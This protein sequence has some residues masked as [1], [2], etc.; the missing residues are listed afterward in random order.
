MCRV[1]DGVVFICSDGIYKY[2]I[3]DG[4]VRRVCRPLK[5]YSAKA[6][7]LRYD[8]NTLIYYS[9]GWGAVLVDCRTWKTRRASFGGGDYVECMFV[10]SKKRIWL[11]F[12]SLGKGLFCYDIKGRLLQRYG[13]DESPF[14][15]IVLCMNEHHG[16]ILV[17]TD[18]N[19]VFSID[20]STHQAQAYGHI[21]GDNFYALPSNSICAIHVD[22]FDNMWAG[23]VRSGLLCVRPV[24]IRTFY[25]VPF[26]NPHGLSNSS[27]LCFHEEAPDRIW[28]GTDGGGLDLYSP[29]TDEFRHFESTAG[30]KILSICGLRP[31]Q[32]L[33]RVFARGIFVFNTLTGKQT[34][35][36][37]GRAATDAL[38]ARIGLSSELSQLDADNVLLCA[39]DCYLLNIRT[40]AVRKIKW[41]GGTKLGRNLHYLPSLCGGVFLHDATSIYQFNA[42][43]DTLSLVCRLKGDNVRINAVVRSNYGNFCIATNRG[44]YVYRYYTREFCPKPAYLFQN[45]NA[46]VTD[47]HRRLWLAT[48]NKVFVWINGQR[49]YM[50]Y[51]EMDGVL[52][53]EYVPRASFMSSTGDIYFGGTSGMVHIDK[54]YK[55]SK[56]TDPRILLTD[57]SINGASVPGIIARNHPELSVGW[58]DNISLRVMSVEH[59]L[60]R[61]KVYRFLIKGYSDNYTE[62]FNPQLDLRSLPSGHYQILASVMQIDGSWTGWQQVLDLTMMPPWYLNG[63]FVTACI[64]ILLLAL[65]FAS[66]SVLRRREERMRWQINSHERQ[67][68][69]DKMRF[70]IDITHELR[71]PLT[72]IH[73]PLDR[74]TKTLPAS[75]PYYERLKGL[76]RQTVRMKHLINMVLDVHKMETTE[77]KLH[78]QPHP[79]H[80][81]LRQVADDFASEGQAQNITTAYDFDPRIDMLSFDKDKCDM[82]LN[83]LLG[84]ALKHSSPGGHITVR[85][86]LSDDGRFVRISVSDDGPGMQGVDPGKLFSRFYQG[87][88]ETVGSGIGLSYSKILVEQHGGNIGA[89]NNEVAGATF[90]FELPMTAQPGDLV[91]QPHPCL[92]ELVETEPRGGGRITLAKD[93]DM[94]GYVLLVVDD[95]KALTDFLKESLRSYFKEVRTASDGVEALESINADAPDVVVSDVMMPRKDGFA[96]CKDIKEN[97]TI[98]HIVVILL[99]A[100]DDNSSQ[101]AG[102]KNGADGYVT[103]PFEIDTLLE[104]LG[105]RL[106]SR[107]QARNRYMSAGLL[108][109]VKDTTF[110]SADEA[111]MEQLDKVISDNISNPDIDIPMLC[112]E[113]AMSRSALY[114]KLKAITNMGSNDYVTKFRMETAVRLMKDTDLSFTDIS[115]KVGISSSRYFSTLFK[116]FIGETPTSY[117]KKLEEDKERK[118]PE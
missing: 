105:N 85:T 47:K 83:N 41:S 51:D 46:L 78:L 67:V 56:I 15:N 86:R 36:V 18:G 108:P 73:A 107:Q 27:A 3:S 22:R 76:Q 50:M 52:R 25:E 103:K 89:Y 102:Y 81:W 112:R 66:R 12:L 11:S 62:T 2:T 61:Q 29:S 115:E 65:F 40:S 58:D 24:T 55:V 26:G 17:G 99:T 91:N 75:N 79:L 72:L 68:N 101:I 34:P 1:K 98:S 60:L 100:R 45:V 39:D 90:Y 6:K 10:D 8:D 88:N 42:K 33:I 118:T 21:S 116:Q 9:S 13:G 117:R 20:P 113:M 23:T 54:D 95:N 87:G 19:G 104:L 28:V 70:L 38:L 44:W 77:T 32:L 63:W 80:E 94:S 31:H 69:V 106:R 82:V 109:V 35:F 53:N 30:E 71:T 59:N 43:L 93:F 7:I 74:M 92:A 57:L 5:P 14:G 16:H 64:L 84:N 111:F 48:D 37:T 4:I 96:L 114:K 110:S 49:R 97:V